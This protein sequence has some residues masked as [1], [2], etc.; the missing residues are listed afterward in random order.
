MEA[1][2]TVF[3]GSLQ[4]ALDLLA[5]AVRSP[6][7]AEGSLPKIRERLRRY[8]EIQDQ[9]PPAVAQELARDKIFR[10][11]PYARAS[12]PA[13][14]A[15]QS[16]SRDDLAT[17]HKAAYQPGRA[18]LTL[19]GDFRPES[20]LEGI[21][22]SFGKW[23]APAPDKNPLEVPEVG[24]ADPLTGEFSRLVTAPST[25]VLLAYPG[26]P[27]RDA[28]F[29]LLKT[30]GTI[31]SARG[32]VDLVLQQPLASS[33]RS[34]LD[35]FSRGG[36]MTLEAGGAA[37]ADTS[38]IAYE[39]MLR[40]RAL[41]LKEVTQETIRDVRAVEKGRLLREKEV[42]Y[43]QASNLGY[44]ELVGPGFGTYDEGKTL[45]AELSASAIKDAAARYLDTSRLVRVVTG[46]SSR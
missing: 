29:P 34:G 43:T 24:A 23:A 44:Y 31:L 19:V 15:L 13:D 25:D 26:V 39:L 8:R 45:P 7:F 5:G 3:S 14:A 18:V 32:T 41:A 1:G 12:L 11:H 16:L 22:S 46:G 33:I 30:L 20:A 38:R 4:S 6:A 35:G 37:S 21:Q 40:A 2:L 27:L 28:Q 10:N 9:S 17:F 36:I 42:L